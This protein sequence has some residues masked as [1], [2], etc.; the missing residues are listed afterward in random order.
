M[1]TFLQATVRNDSL[2]LKGHL[3]ISLNT[4]QENDSGL[5]RA[6]LVHIHTLVK[7]SPG[8]A[9]STVL[10]VTHSSLEKGLL[11]KPLLS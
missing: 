10:E 4:S 2:E 8:P 3:Y 11:L 6:H 7:T 9:S 1:C 5:G